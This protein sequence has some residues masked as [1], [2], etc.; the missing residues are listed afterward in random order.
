MEKEIKKGYFTSILLCCAVLLFFNSCNYQN[1]MKKIT[2][3]KIDKFAQDYINII[4]NRNY[5]TA[6]GLLSPEIKKT[7]TNIKALEKIGDILNIDELVSIEQISYHF[8][9][10][11]KTK[12]RSHVLAY[13]LEFKK[14]WIIVNIRIDIIK[15]KK[16]IYAF[17]A[18]YLPASLKT[19][20]AF[21]LS[22]KSFI[23]YLFILVALS[24]IALDIYALILIFKL[25]MKKKWLWIIF[26]FIGICAFKINWST[27]EFSF[28]LFS[29]SIYIFNF[30]M[31]RYG[32]YAPW[33]LTLSM[34]IGAL[35]IFI[36]SIGTQK[37]HC[38]DC[39]KSFKIVERYGNSN[40]CNNCIKKINHRSQP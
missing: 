10:K 18:N 26:I 21:T 30:Q 40:L 24:I 16:Y 13:Q 14:S 4:K 20:N 17:N 38:M 5:Q 8:Q 2:P 27:G 29:I 35:A 7:P 31:L 6:I 25:K 15:D 39:K 9:K 36:S 34:P 3:A 37:R 1:A 12:C 33:I 11:W 19:I 32:L 28:Q 23:H 22:G